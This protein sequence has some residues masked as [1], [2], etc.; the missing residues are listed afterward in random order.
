MT[1]DGAADILEGLGKLD[2]SDKQDRNK[3]EMALIEFQ[4]DNG[5]TLG[6]GLDVATV[7][8]LR[9]APGKQAEA[10]ALNRQA[11]E[12]LQA[13]G[14]LDPAD[15]QNR[16]KFQLALIG[17]QFANGLDPDGEIDPKTF[18]ALAEAALTSGWEL[19]TAAVDDDRA[20]DACPYMIEI[21]GGGFTLGRDNGK[22]EQGPPA[23][24]DIAT[25]ALA[26][27]EIT[28]E[29]FDAYIEARGLDQLTS[30]RAPEPTC[31]AWSDDNRMRRTEFE[32]KLDA[33]ADLEDPVSCVSLQD[34]LGYIDWLN[35][36]VEG[37]PFRLPTE[38]EFEYALTR[39]MVLSGKVDGDI[40]GCTLRNSAD[41]SSQFDWKDGSCDDGFARVAPVASMSE[42]GLGLFD[43]SGNVWEWV[44]DCWAPDHGE[45]P[46]TDSARCETGTVK[47]GSFDDPPDNLHPTVRQGVP[48]KRRQTNIGFRLARDLN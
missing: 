43:M 4:L 45:T 36:Q 34:T 48:A 30:G 2:A 8:A 37:A 7:R 3:V 5:L 46:D 21:G 24:V 33:E 13:I 20:C 42:D 40:P 6:A 41:A 31:Y 19:A 1:L 38:A 32:F 17:F 22:P 9:E 26:E 14:R 39:G 25:F 15:M 44:A 11:A 27:T 16:D 12:M 47:G 18:A 23:T 29:E 35:Q 10:E 28:I